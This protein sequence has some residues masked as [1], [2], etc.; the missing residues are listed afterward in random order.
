MRIRTAIAAAAATI[1]ATATAALALSNPL[2]AQIRPVGAAGV[3]GNVTLFQMGSNVN[4][5]V[6]LTS[7][8]A[9]I[10]DLRKGSCASYDAKARPLIDA[11]QVDLPAMKLPDLIG[12]VV[13]LHK[14]SDVGSPVVGCAEVKGS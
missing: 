12:S 13:L 8:T 14:G 1:L 2:V 10:I 5:G 3:R 9:G 6:N 7:G 4:L 11:Q